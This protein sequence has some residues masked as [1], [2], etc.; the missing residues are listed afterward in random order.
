MKK[1]KNY[2]IWSVILVVVIALVFLNSSNTHKPDRTIPDSTDLTVAVK[3]ASESPSDETPEETP[4]APSVNETHT[5][6]KVYQQPEESIIVE[7]QESIPE[8][9]PPLPPEDQK[10]KEPE[11]KE[12][13]CTLTVKCDTILNNINRLKDEKLDIIPADGIIFAE[14]AIEFNEGDSV[15]D[16]LLREM[17]LGGIHMEF[18]NTPMY[19]SAYIKGIGNIYEYD[20]GSLSGWLYKVNGL[21]PNCGCSQ[22]I[23]QNGDK[24]EWVYTCDMGN[25]TSKER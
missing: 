23:V 21:V 25:D 11:F 13:T 1:Y 19:D 12:L 15:F 3:P 7:N 14:K 16:I 6:Q 22:Y 17:K 10:N 9:E 4:P 24:I 2:I 5:D 20:C 18:E 8:Y